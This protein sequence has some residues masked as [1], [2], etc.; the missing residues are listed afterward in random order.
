MMMCD[1][2]GYDDGV[3]L[4]GMMKCDFG[5]DDDVWF[6]M[7]WRCVIYFFGELKF[8]TNFVTMYC[9]VRGIGGI[10]WG[11][12]NII[13]WAPAQQYELSPHTC[14]GYGVQNASVF[15]HYSYAQS[16]RWVHIFKKEITTH[17]VKRK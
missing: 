5:R 9:C 16:P 7:V 11:D 2:G 12:T 10:C 14:G 4:D 15:V 1:F 17:F 13:I 3:I 6:W 8:W